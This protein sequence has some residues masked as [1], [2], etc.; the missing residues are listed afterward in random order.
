MKLLKCE[1]MQ[2]KIEKYIDVVACIK[3]E[4]PR[5]TLLFSINLTLA[6][7]LLPPSCNTYLSGIFIGN[8]EIARMCG[9]LLR[10]EY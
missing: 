7:L 1:S 3:K 5:R 9:Y 2:K 10:R 6:S 8:Q 4:A